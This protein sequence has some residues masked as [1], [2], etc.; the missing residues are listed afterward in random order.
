M[1]DGYVAT[2][3][4]L[5]RLLQGPVLDR[6][7]IAFLMKPY[8]AQLSMSNSK[9]LHYYENFFL[10]QNCNVQAI[11]IN[12]NHDLDITQLYSPFQGSTTIYRTH[13]HTHTH[14]HTQ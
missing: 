10:E 5:I 8:K 1:A 13:T 14:A 3:D 9:S 6:P 7:T 12:Q 4:V 11:C 2:L